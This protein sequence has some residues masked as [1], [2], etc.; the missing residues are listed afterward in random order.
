MFRPSLRQAHLGLNPCK[1]LARVAVPVRHASQRRNVDKIEWKWFLLV[2]AFGTMVYVNV[3]QR[4]QE[5]DHSKNLEKYKKTFTEDEWNKYISEIQK[6]HLTLEKGEECYLLPVTNG[7]SKDSEVVKQIV[8]KLGAKVIDLNEL[9]ERQLEGGKYHILLKENLETHD[10]KANGFAYSFT[11]RL[12][13]GIFTQLV[14]DE[15]KKEK[16]ADPGA[17]RFL[18]L[19]YPPNIKEAIK[20]EQNVCSR[21]TLLVLKDEEDNNVVEY[22]ETVDKIKHVKDLPKLDP[23]DISHVAKPAPLLETPQLKMLAD[24]QPSQDAPAIEKAQW[25]LR[26]LGQPIRQ[27]GESDEDV[28]TRLKSLK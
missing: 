2:A 8:E 1:L 23:L 13:P 22:F 19:N 14:S 26:Q 9:V 27:Y 6:K 24:T 28:I 20:F 18:L 11:Y 25:Q 16:D 15:I 5:Q 7:N 21:D 10:P 17:G 12:K 4:I 3:M